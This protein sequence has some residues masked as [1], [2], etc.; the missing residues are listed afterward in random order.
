MLN[1]AIG[2][3]IRYNSF[4]G[5][6]IEDKIRVC[7]IE[8]KQYELKTQRGHTEW[9]V[10]FWRISG[11]GQKAPTIEWSDGTKLQHP[12]I[13]DLIDSLTHLSERA[14]LSGLARNELLLGHKKEGIGSE[15][16]WLYHRALRIGYVSLAS[17]LIERRHKM[18]LKTLP[19]RH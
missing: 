14:I 9:G 2:H 1:D 4:Y 13:K 16:A 17:K 3:P 11:F 18:G 12:A 8:S 5:Q 10:D 7:F 19:P 6:E 15:E